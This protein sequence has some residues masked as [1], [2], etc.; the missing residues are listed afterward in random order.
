MK[1][2]LVIA[3]ILF[4]GVTGVY[5]MAWSYVKTGVNPLKI[6]TKDS[7]QSVNKQLFLVILVLNLIIIGLYCFSDQYY[8]FTSPILFLDTLF[9]FKVTG[10]VLLLIAFVLMFVAQQQMKTSWR[11]GIDTHKKTSL[12]IQGLFRYSRNPIL[13]G[14]LIAVIGFFFILPNT[15]TFCIIILGYYGIGIQIRLEEHYL[16]E[17]HSTI[18]LKYKAKVRRWI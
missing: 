3:V 7:I 8:Q 13:L 10:S 12:I 5:R 1:I 15:I 2:I 6:K 4:Y 14:L 11:M 16:E 18:Y 9:F 17:K